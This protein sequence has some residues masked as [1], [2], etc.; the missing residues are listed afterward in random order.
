MPRR[1]AVKGRSRRIEWALALA[2]TVLALGLLEVGLRVLR[3]TGVLGWVDLDGASAAPVGPMPGFSVDPQLG[4]RPTQGVGGYDARG[5]V[6][7]GSSPETCDGP[8]LAFA[9]DSVVHRGALTGALAS[10]LEGRYC[11]ANAGVEAYDAEQSRLYAARILEPLSPERLVFALHPNDFQVTPVLLKDGG[12][13]RMFVGLR[14]VRVDAGWFRRSYLFRLGTSLRARSLAASARPVRSV[15]DE[16]AEDLRHDGVHFTVLVL[17]TFADP[18]AWSRAERRAY[19]DAVAIVHDLGLE[20][21]D[22]REPLER[23]VEAGLPLQESPGDRWH[24]S[25]ALGAAMA[26]W[27]LARGF[28]TT[29]SR[30]SR[31]GAPPP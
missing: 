13:L 20:A 9:G 5:L 3:P 12:A 23:A 21:F 24:P 4:F 10:R 29:D 1:P 18:A 11:F 25:E 31:T 2:S 19:R 22:L 26:E 30:A 17:P 27:L 15:L 7:A 8:W 6:E 14:E 16:W 28:P